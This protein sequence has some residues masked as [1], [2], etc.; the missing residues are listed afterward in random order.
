MKSNSIKLNYEQHQLIE[1][2]ESE[3][4]LVNYLRKKYHLG[5]K[6]CERE[7]E[8][9]NYKIEVLK[10]QFLLERENVSDTCQL[11]Y[12]YFKNSTVF[13]CRVPIK[14]PIKLIV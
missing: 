8:L 1:A 13:S 3:I 9:S 6:L 4:K 10:N 5:S 12:A 2:L 7:E 14:A 11:W